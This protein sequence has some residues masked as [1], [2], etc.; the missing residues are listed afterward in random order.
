MTVR[1]DSNELLQAGRRVT[2]RATLGLAK[3]ADIATTDSPVVHGGPATI[4]DVGALDGV[5]LSRRVEL[6]A[7]S[8]ARNN[9]RGTQMARWA[10]FDADWEAGQ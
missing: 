2:R 4:A 7:R 8:Q 6:A 5:D 3:T 9:V 10:S 1:P